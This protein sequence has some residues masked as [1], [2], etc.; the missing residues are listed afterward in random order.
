M[1]EAEWAELAAQAAA[2]AER[3]AEV[4]AYMAEDVKADPRK[5]RE[6]QQ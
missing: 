3:I 5:E 2:Q 1:S 4:A 6:A